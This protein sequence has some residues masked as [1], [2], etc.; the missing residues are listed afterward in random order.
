MTHFLRISVYCKVSSENELKL[1]YTLKMS[2]CPF[3]FQNV[4]CEWEINFNGNF[5]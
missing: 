3:V 5:K 4:H 2:Y 1:K